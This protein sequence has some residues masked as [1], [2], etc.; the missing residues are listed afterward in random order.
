MTSTATPAL[1]YY[2]PY[3]EWA[4]T[5]PKAEYDLAGSNI[6]ACTLDDLPGARD[7]IA[8]N[9]ANDTG[10]APLIEAIAGR[11]GVDARHV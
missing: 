10:Y 11:Y 6:L 5:R 9:G 1:R 2:A 7:A 8:L 3:M 4:K